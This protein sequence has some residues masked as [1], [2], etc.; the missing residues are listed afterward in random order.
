MSEALK[1]QDQANVIRLSDR[2][3]PQPQ[4]G[5]KK[6]MTVLE[7]PYGAIID[8]TDGLIEWL[9]AIGGDTS[10]LRLGADV[11]AREAAILYYQ[12][13]C[14]GILITCQ[15]MPEIRSTSLTWLGKWQNLFRGRFPIEAFLPFIAKGRS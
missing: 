7:I 11:T 5:K 9:Y 14:R 6:Y 4:T 3:K 2:R 10:K 12:A 8:D 13:R 1:A 15:A